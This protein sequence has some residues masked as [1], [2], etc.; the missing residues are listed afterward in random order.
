VRL[1]VE[2]GLVMWEEARLETWW[3]AVEMLQ[4]EEEEGRP[5]ALVLAVAK[6]PT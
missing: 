2:V 1:V 6:N 3:L 4:T 5:R